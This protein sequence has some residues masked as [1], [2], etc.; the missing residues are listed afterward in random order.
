MAEGRGEESH[1]ANRTPNHP[2]IKEL[3]PMRTLRIEMNRGHGWELRAAGKIPT[4]TSVEL[5]RRDLQDY[6]AQYPHRALLDGGE[7]ARAGELPA[8]TTAREE[9]AELVAHRDDGRR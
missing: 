1:R 6:A 3:M 5:I 2:D 4:G 9:F 8:A 7:V